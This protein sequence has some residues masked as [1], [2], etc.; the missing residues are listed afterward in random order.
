M[1]H[2]PTAVASGLTPN[3]HRV[4]NPVEDTIPLFAATPLT[5]VNHFY[6]ALSLVGA[7]HLS[8]KT[9]R[10]D[11]VKQTNAELDSMSPS[12]YIQDAGLVGSTPYIREMRI[13]APAGLAG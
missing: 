8:E 11:I 12:D 5:P 6:A 1:S 10:P 4:F 9:S 3:K 7:R 13:N 2:A